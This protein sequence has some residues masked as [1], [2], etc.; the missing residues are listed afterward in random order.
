MGFRVY[1]IVVFLA[2]LPKVPA[3]SKAC[4]VLPTEAKSVLEHRFHDWRLKSVSDLS[5]YDKK[6]WLETHPKEC[7]GIAVGHFEQPDRVAYAVLLVPKSKSTG[8]YKIVVLN[9]TSD[10]YMV[11]LLDR[12]DGSTYSDSGLVISKER[13]G[14]YFGLW[15]YQISA[16]KGRWHKR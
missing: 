15:R 11:T 8:S 12:A 7:P 13:R 16:L 6:L 4:D 10:E 3:Q 14:T 5:G 9:K 1:T 2:L